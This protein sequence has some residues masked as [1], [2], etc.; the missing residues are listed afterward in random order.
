M[1]KIVVLLFLLSPVVADAQAISFADMP[2]QVYCTDSEGGIRYSFH[3]QSHPIS[4]NNVETSYG[5]FSDSPIAIPLIFDRI[6][7][8]IIGEPGPIQTS[9]C[10]EAYIQN[11]VATGK[12]FY[13][14][15]S[16]KPQTLPDVSTKRKAVTETVTGSA[17]LQ[18]DDA[19][20]LPVKTGKT[21]IVSGTVFALSTHQ[22]P[23]IK[24]AFTAP[25]GS[26]IAIGYT[27]NEGLLGSSGELQV[28]G[29]ASERI[30]LTV[31]TVVPVHIE[32]TV[33]AGGNGTL[34]LQWAQSVSNNHAVK[35][36]KGSYLKLEEVQ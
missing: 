24:I 9:D 20:S 26:D 33:V 12:A 32:G 27:S 23:D 36:N 14:V 11:L 15:K 21:Y 17:A 10:H 3:P 7:G 13:Y 5:Y 6:T 30:P 19:L 34:Q 4:T 25:S 31:N 29:V 18:N 22:I 16:S 2:D 28:S 1:K 8:Q 35:V